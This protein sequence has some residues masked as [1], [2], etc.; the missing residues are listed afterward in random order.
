MTYTAWDSTKPT[1]SQTRQAAIDSIRTN[2]TALRDA[3]MAGG[4][5]G[6]AY[7]QSGGTAE[8]P[9]TMYLTSGAIIL[10]AAVTWTSGNPTGFTFSLSTD[11]GSSYDTIG[12]ASVLTFDGSGNLTASTNWG[13]FLWK[14]CIELLGKFKSLRTTYTAHAA[15]SS[16]HG[17]GT[18]AAQAANNVAVTGG[19]ID[20][21]TIGGTTAALGRFK[22]AREL[23]ATPSFGATTTLDCSAAGSFSF[24]A[25]GTGAATLALSNVPASGTAMSIVVTIV[26]AGL[27]TWTWPTNTR[28]EGGAAPSGLPSSGRTVLT[29]FTDDGGSN[30]IGGIYAVNAS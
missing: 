16:A 18:I 17:I 10:K 3:F 20:G 28:W 1:T 21:T 9:T 7:S 30:I 22:Q 4:M 24:T 14:L 8:E 15:S 6:F 13:G 2:L 29:F 11:T 27:R 23:R 5:P 26:N 12:S 25:T 19:T